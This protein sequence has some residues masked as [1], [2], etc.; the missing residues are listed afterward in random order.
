MPESTGVP[1]RFRRRP[2]LRHA[3]V[4]AARMYRLA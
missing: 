2:R 4:P 3:G 1:R